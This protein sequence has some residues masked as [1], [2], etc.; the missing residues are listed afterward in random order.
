VRIQKKRQTCFLIRFRFFRNTDVTEAE[1]SSSS[2]ALLSCS[3][4]FHATCL[5][6]LEH[7]ALDDGARLDG[8]MAHDSDVTCCPASFKCPVCRSLYVKRLVPCDF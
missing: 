5:L 8:R 1:S 7:F 4:V 6:A 2:V 3:H